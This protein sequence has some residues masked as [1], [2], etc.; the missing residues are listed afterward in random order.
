LTH[1]SESTPSFQPSSYLTEAQAARYLNVSLSTMRRWR[2][3]GQGPRHFRV[4]DILRYHISDL[5]RF[6]GGHLRGEVA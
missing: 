3:E 1:I 4:G 5:D 2:R 6:V